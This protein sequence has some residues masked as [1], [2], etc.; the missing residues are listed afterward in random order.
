ML[1]HKDSEQINYTE[2][3]VLVF[4]MLC[5]LH[6]FLIIILSDAVNTGLN[7]VMH[8]PVYDSYLHT[9]CCHYQLIIAYYHMVSPYHRLCG[10]AVNLLYFFFVRRV[11]YHVTIGIAKFK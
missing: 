6:F 9:S 1:A 8:V 3:H 4:K 5:T 10:I 11:Y 2:I 7:F